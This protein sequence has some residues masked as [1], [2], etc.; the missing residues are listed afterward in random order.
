MK[1]TATK[2]V[3][4]SWFVV[5]YI[6]ISNL[7]FFSVAFSPTAVSKQSWMQLQKD[8]FQFYQSDL[9]VLCMPSSTEDKAQAM[10]RALCALQPLQWP[11]AV[12][13]NRL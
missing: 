4:L 6:I 8:P 12:A 5:K 10:G 13:K 11:G 3:R 2:E 7:V 9:I 1:D